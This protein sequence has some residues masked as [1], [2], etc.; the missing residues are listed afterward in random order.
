V[1]LAVIIVSANDARWLEPCLQSVAVHAAGLELEAIV[2]DNDSSDGTR[3]L[4]QARIP[5]ARVLSSPNRGFA[6][7]NNRGLEHTQ[8]RYV[9]LLNPDTE[10]LHGELAELIALLDRTPEIGI[11]GVRQVD[12]EDRPLSTMRRFPNAARALGEALRCERWPLRPTWVGERVLDPAAYLREHDCDWT[13][14]SFM[15]IR[16]EALLAAGVLDERFFLYCEETDLCLRVRRAGWRVRHLPQMTIRHYAGKSGVRPALVAQDAL[17]RRLY[18]Y[19]HFATPHRQLF[20]AAIA[21]RHAI[22]LV[23]AQL[24]GLAARGSTTSSERSTRRHAAR[25]ALRMLR[26]S[27]DF[28]FIAPPPVALAVA[29]PASEPQPVASELADRPASEPQPDALFV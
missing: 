5:Q 27:A 3:E 23:G 2:V 19:K 14:G 25:W 11:A 8:A 10:I 16:R 7:G 21:L 18:A 4:V 15:L 22:G 12:G 20:L 28:P 29:Q 1:D 17:S 24:M 26:G 6:Y 13:A 9:L